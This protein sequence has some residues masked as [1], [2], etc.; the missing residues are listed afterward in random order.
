MRFTHPDKIIF[1]DIK[2]SK[3]DVLNYYQDIFPIISQFIKDRPISIER[4]PRGIKEL[5]FMQKHFRS[6]LPH[7]FHAFLLM[8]RKKDPTSYV[9]LDN[10]NTLQYLV[11]LNAVVF[12]M[13]LSKRERINNPE[14]IVFDLD[15]V[16]ARFI[17]LKNG[18]RIIFDYFKSQNIDSFIFI[19][20]SRGVHIYIPLKSIYSFETTKKYASY[21]ATLL[22]NTYPKLFTVET[23]KKNR[24]GKIFIDIARNAFG[25]TVVIPFSIRAYFNAPICFPVSWKVF[26]S[27]IHSAH[28]ITI[29]NYKKNILMAKKVLSDMTKTKNEIP[30]F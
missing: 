28:D 20:G 30:K 13:W 24:H 26:F 29:L 4:Y 21:V 6:V 3:R 25:Q 11:Q 15:P 27:R 10:K 14:F 1:P 18:S 12:H 8:N 9:S 7:W 2:I 23:R 16:S 19:T 5:G 17:D 22:T